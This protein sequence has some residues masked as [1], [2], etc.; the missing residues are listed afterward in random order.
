MVITEHRP[1]EF[2][3]QV[4]FLGVTARAGRGGVAGS[5][6]AAYNAA[7]AEINANR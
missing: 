2:I 4:Y 7:I 6:A 3:W 1:G 5:W